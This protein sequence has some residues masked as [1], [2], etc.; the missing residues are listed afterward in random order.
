MAYFPRGATHT[1]EL[2]KKFDEVAPVKIPCVAKWRYKFEDDWSGDPAV[3]FWVTLTD[4]ASR[5]ENLRASRTAF[6]DIVSQHVDLFNDWGL[7][8]YFHF[9]SESEQARIN[10]EDYA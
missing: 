9:R 2:I 4:D 7:I 1:S 3:F 10:G 6:T 8:P 5:G